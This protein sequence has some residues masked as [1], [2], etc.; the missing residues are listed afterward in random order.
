MRSIKKYQV[1][2]RP[3]IV[4]KINRLVGLGS[5]A[6]YQFKLIAPTSPSWPTL[7]AKQLYTLFY[8]YRGYFFLCIPG[9][10]PTYSPIQDPREA[11]KIDDAIELRLLR[12]S[13]AIM[14]E[15]VL[16]ALPAA[17]LQHLA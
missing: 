4:A 16:G 15:R 14:L 3:L 7:A 6:R 11:T 2:S 17:T 13:S 5:L 8:L 9:N 10:F 1:R 12:R